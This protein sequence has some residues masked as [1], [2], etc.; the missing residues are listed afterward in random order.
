VQIRRFAQDDMHACVYGTT[1][2]SVEG[3]AD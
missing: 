2:W 3:V 1:E